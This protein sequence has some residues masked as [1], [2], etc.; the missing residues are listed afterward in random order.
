MC[1]ENKDKM[2]MHHHGH[3]KKVLVIV[4]VAL[5]LFLVAKTVSEIWS[6]PYISAGKPAVNTISVSGKGEV[7]AI[8][9][10]ATFTYSVTE[11]AKTVS[12]AQK[13]ST[14]KGNKAIKYLKDQGI[15]DKDIKTTDY[16][17][18]P[19]YD[20]VTRAIA[21]PCT[22][23]SCPPV[24]GERVL[25]SYSVSQTVQVKIR[26]TEKAGDILSGIGQLEVQNVSSLN[27]EVD[28]YDDLQHNA[29][30][31]AIDDAKNQAKILA[32]DLG[33]KI[34]RV[35]S[36]N[37]GGNY[38]VPMYSKA[39]MSLDSSGRGEAMPSPEI[40]VGEQKITSNVS[41]VYEIR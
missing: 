16:S 10:I 40:S 38:A 32:K 19:N 33:V 13:K 25:K 11:E 29:R 2:C 30:K 27:F 20:Y 1:E 34:G 15:E 23:Y 8:P 5:S 18:Y 24:T 12:E 4:G 17:V 26:N 21:M 14:E 22:Q 36:F 7:M 28:K 41:I 35:V 31:L 6:Y 39:V 3:F 37:E 9:D